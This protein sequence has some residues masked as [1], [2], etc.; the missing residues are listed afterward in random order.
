[1]AKEPPPSAGAPATAEVLGKLHRSNVKEI[2]MGEMARDHGHSKE[3]QSFG[4]TLIKDHTEADDKVAKLAKEEKIDLAANTPEVGSTDMN[5]GAGFDAEFAR[6]M[7]D[8]HK[9]DIA[10]V[11]NARDATKDER[12]KSLLKELLP[13][14]KK[15]ESI[16]QK[17]VNQGGNALR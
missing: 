7:L 17:L 13:T 16:A 1:M 14:L 6:T 9:K 3:V 15:H 12:L 8:D 10:A 11:E 5:M 4:K 2:R